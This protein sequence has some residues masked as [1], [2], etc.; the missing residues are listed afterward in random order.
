MLAS[1]LTSCEHLDICVHLGRWLPGVIGA[2]L[3]ERLVLGPGAQRALAA[4]LGL[5]ASELSPDCQDWRQLITKLIV[6]LCGVRVG[7]VEF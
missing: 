5:M 3:C 1:E 2:W 6:L 7:Q 4:C